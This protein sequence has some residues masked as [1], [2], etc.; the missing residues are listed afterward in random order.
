MLVT[1]GF[2]NRSINAVDENGER[3]VYADS[4]EFDENFMKQRK[5]ILGLNAVSTKKIDEFKKR[6]KRV[7]LA[8][9]KALEQLRERRN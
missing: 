5:T 8:R 6:E 7:E 9:K 3:Y 4:K 1:F 2:I